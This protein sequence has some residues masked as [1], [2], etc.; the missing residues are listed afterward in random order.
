MTSLSYTIAFKQN[1]SVTQNFTNSI[2][3]FNEYKIA[4]GVKIQGP[5]LTGA[6]KVEDNVFFVRVSDTL[7]FKTAQTVTFTPTKTVATFI[8]SCR[9]LV[10]TAVVEEQKATAPYSIT[11]TFINPISKVVTTRKSTGV[12]T[13]YVNNP[14]KTT[15]DYVKIPGCGDE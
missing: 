1:Y 9:K 8:P 14:I 4:D 2:S 11:F 15:L 12:W 5:T 10:G 7:K 13:G 6:N 3:S